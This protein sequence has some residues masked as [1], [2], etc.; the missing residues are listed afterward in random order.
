MWGIKDIVVGLL[1]CDPSC[2][3]CDGPST[4]DC[5]QCGANQVAENDDCVCD[6][7]TGFLA[8]NYF[9]DTDGVCKTTCSGGYYA[10]PLTHA[11]EAD[12]DV[13][14]NTFKYLHSAST[15]QQKYCVANCPAGFWKYA[16]NMSCVAECYDPNIAI[17]SNYY[18]FN[19]TDKVCYQDCPDGYVADPVS[20][21]CVT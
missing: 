17:E 20:G 2:V 4:S 18:N 9:N 21:Y 8:T 10:D 13:T 6:S 7:G 15:T 12:C 1:I 14:T 3:E 11:C 5:T 19:G 16:V